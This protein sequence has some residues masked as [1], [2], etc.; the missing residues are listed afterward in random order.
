MDDVTEGGALLEAGG[1][2][3][4]HQLVHFGGASFWWGQLQLAG[5]Q[6]CKGKG[7]HT[8]DDV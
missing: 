3:A 2:A 7:P 4:D 6:A 8:G 5:L 1:P